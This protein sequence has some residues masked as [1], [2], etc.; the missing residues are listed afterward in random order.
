MRATYVYDSK[1]GDRNIYKVLYVPGKD[2]RIESNGRFK[3]FGASEISPNV[4]LQV[5]YQPVSLLITN[6]KLESSGHDETFMG[7]V[8]SS[9]N[10]TFAIPGTLLKETNIKLSFELTTIP[11]NLIISEIGPSDVSINFPGWQNSQISVV[12]LSST[13]N[14]NTTLTVKT[15]SSGGGG[16]GPVN[17]G[18][19]TDGSEDIQLTS[20]NIPQM[21]EEQLLG[22]IRLMTVIT[23][24]YGKDVTLG[25]LFNVVLAI[26]EL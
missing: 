3:S 2:I 26:I 20:L 18:S 21:G 6:P 7:S 10:V 23:D 24:E 9:R 1:E 14:I 4:V 13:Y 11:D 16:G 8:D 22:S 19:P 5:D 12:K 17:P 25:S 15:G